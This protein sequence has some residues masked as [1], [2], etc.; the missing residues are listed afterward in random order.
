LKDIE[1]TEIETR[2]E[3]AR[4]TTTDRLERRTVYRLFMIVKGT[5]IKINES[6]G[7]DFISGLKVRIDSMRQQAVS[8]RTSG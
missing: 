8:R 5:R 3:T 7:H 2:E 6:Y 4:D 1:R